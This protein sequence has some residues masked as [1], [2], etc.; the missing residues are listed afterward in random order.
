MDDFTDHSS[1]DVENQ[2]FKCSMDFTEGIL[3]PSHYTTN[4]AL[5][6]STSLSANLVWWRSNPALG[7]KIGGNVLTLP[8][9]EDPIIVQPYASRM[10]N[11]NPFNVF[12]FIGRIDLLPASDDWTDT[13]RVPAR[14]T[15][16]EGNFRA[17]RERL[18]TNNRGFALFSGE[19]GEL[20]GLVREEL[21]LEH[22]EK[23]HSLVV[24]RDVFCKVR[25]LLRH[26]VRLDLV[27]D[28]ESFLELT[29]VPW[30]IASSI[31][32]SSHGSALVM[33]DS[34]LNVWL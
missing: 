13:R 34:T 29:V 27:L 14:V 3:R 28:S 24:Y 6:Y 30:V 5:Q 11:V 21:A 18:G 10:E 31:A 32:H 23:P 2:D 1:S 15:T 19:H 25:P 9:E 26:V 7:G 20:P 33:S 8:Y 22:G 4:V 16:I 12:T 17:T